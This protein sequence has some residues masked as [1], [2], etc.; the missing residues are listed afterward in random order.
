MRL[1]IVKP[2][3]ESIENYT[4]VDV[5]PNTIDLS[6]VSDNECTSI[7]ANDVLD[8]FSV[9]N[10]PSL[11]AQL[12]KKIRMGG[13]LVVG[14]TDI[15]LFCKFVT[16]DQIDE[17]SAT[18]LLGS[19]QSMTTLNHTVGILMELGLKIVSSQINGVHYEIKASRG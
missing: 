13:E 9:E 17:L 10:V 6:V 16:N 5:A 4:R 15:R 3:Q 7:L 12:V 8:S 2:E 11:L 1:Q 18:R 19:I 14:G